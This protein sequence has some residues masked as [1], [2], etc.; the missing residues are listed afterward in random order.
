MLSI[1]NNRYQFYCKNFS[2]QTWFKKFFIGVA[3][4]LDEVRQNI[5]IW[6]AAAADDWRPPIIVMTTATYIRHAVKRTCA[7]NK[8]TTNEAAFLNNRRQFSFLHSTSH[9]FSHFKPAQHYYTLYPADGLQCAANFE[10]RRCL[11][12]ASSLLLTV[13]HTQLSP[14]SDLAFPV[15]SAST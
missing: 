10:T 14:V 2:S 11:R 1:S 8:F 12:S 4:R 15:A 13:C 5:I 9:T 7:T 6:P 3:L